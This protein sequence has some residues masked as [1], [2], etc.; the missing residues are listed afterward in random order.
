MKMLEREKV[1]IRIS[2]SA[3]KL[4]ERSAFGCAAWDVSS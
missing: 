4:K 2:V 1:L 3:E